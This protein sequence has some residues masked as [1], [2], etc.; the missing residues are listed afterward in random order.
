MPPDVSAS[1]RLPRRACR[2]SLTRSQRM[3]GAAPL[4]SAGS[5]SASAR[6][7]ATNASRPSARYGAARR[8]RARSP[9][10]S[11]G[12]VA[13]QAT[14]CCAS[15]SS[16]ASG[17]AWRSSSCA[18]IARA[19]AAASTSSSPRVAMTL[20]RATRVSRCPARPTRCRT[21]AI[22]RGDCVWTTRSMAPTSMPSSS[23]EVATSARSAPPL[24]RS[25]ASSRARRDSEPWWARTLPSGSRS[26]RL[27]ARRS[28]ARRLGA[29]TSVVR[30]AATH[31]AT[32]WSSASHTVSL[33]AVRK[34]ATGVTTSSSIAREKPASTT[35]PP[36]PAPTRKARASS[37]GRTVAEQP[38]RCRPSP[39]R[40][41]SRSSESARCAPRFVAKN[42]WI[43][44][45]MT[46]RALARAGRNL[47]AVSRR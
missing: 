9:S 37:T 23:E 25:S 11:H 7:T 15:T 19:T 6:T 16:G 34:S 43:S 47:S 17:I 36:R 44:S 5:G 13:T 12:P 1:R 39:A 29:K 14:I 21:A 8:Q 26:S 32:C 41:A 42:A 31:S 4:T 2:R 28:A 10:P 45:T 20:P 27:R 30:C 35:A 33:G 18:R 24:R 22:V 40:A 46:N 38:I 3:R